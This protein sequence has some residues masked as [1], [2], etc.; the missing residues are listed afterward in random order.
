MIIVNREYLDGLLLLLLLLLLSLLSLKG[1]APMKRK[2]VRQKK[3]GKQEI[4]FQSSKQPSRQI[5]R[6]LLIAFEK[7]VTSLKFYSTHKWERSY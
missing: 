7:V 3:K 6:F 2:K 4:E 5:G 1:E